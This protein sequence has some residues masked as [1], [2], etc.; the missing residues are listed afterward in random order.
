MSFKMSPAK[1][2]TKFAAQHTK[3]NKGIYYYASVFSASR[4]QRTASKT[5]VDLKYI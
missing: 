4:E 2:I 1:R 5:S 3:Y